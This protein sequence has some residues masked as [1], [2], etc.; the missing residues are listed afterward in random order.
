MSI[1]NLITFLKENG[2]RDAALS[3]ADTYW[4][5]KPSKRPARWQSDV[6]RRAKSRIN[7]FADGHNKLA[8][9]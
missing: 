7:Y 2:Q 3:L 5:A 6:V 4:S 1:E 8:V 9:Y